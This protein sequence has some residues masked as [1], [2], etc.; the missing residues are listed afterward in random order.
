[1]M[2]CSNCVNCLKCQL[3]PTSGPKDMFGRS[4]NV[5]DVGPAL[6][7]QPRPSQ[8]TSGMAAIIT[9]LQR[10]TI[11]RDL[12]LVTMNHRTRKPP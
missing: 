7:A 10:L 8:V 4:P 1:M 6:F 3:D 2:F 11:D 5:L 12:M 9:D